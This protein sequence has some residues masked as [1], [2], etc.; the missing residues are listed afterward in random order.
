MASFSDHG[1][2][3]THWPG[4]QV[5]VPGSSSF[6]TPN[7]ALPA[8]ESGGNMHRLWEPGLL[9]HALHPG[10]VV[11]PSKRFCSVVRGDHVLGLQ[12]ASGGSDLT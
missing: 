2:Q 10:C 11:C 8:I 7:Q 1:R 3:Q 9:R 4:R 12:Q 5:L 6:T